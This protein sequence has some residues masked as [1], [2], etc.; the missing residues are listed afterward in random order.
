CIFSRDLHTRIPSDGLD[1]ILAFTYKERKYKVKTLPASTAQPTSSQKISKNSHQKIIS[2]PNLFPIPSKSQ[3]AAVQ[4]KKREFLEND[5]EVPTTEKR[6]KNSVSHKINPKEES[7]FRHSNTLSSNKST[8]RNSFKDTQILIQD[9]ETPSILKNAIARREARGGGNGKSKS[10]R[11]SSL[12][13]RGKRQSTAHHAPP[14]SS[15][16]PNEYYRHLPADLGDPIRMRQLL[17]WCGNY[18]RK[19]KS[20]KLKEL[21]DLEDPGE[22][23]YELGLVIDIYHHMVKKIT[24]KTINTSWYFRGDAQID[25]SNDSMIVST[26]KKAHPKSAKQN[27]ILANMATDLK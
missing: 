3:Q 13:A 20:D 16:S 24:D 26:H 17:M 10:R 7:D 4:Q 27:E 12:A 2:H 25:V 14:H 11:R 22:E 1:S 6:A 5:F 23:I 21:R 15:I 19:E 8:S 18:L 9:S